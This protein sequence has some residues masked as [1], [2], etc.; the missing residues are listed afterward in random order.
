MWIANIKKLIVVVCQECC[1]TS[2]CDFEIWTFD[3]SKLQI[4]MRVA[5]SLAELIWLSNHT[6]NMKRE[7]VP[8]NFTVCP[9]PKSPS[10]F[11]TNK[12]THTLPPEP[13]S[14]HLTPA[15]HPNTP[16]QSGIITNNN[17]LFRLVVVWCRRPPVVGYRR[18]RRSVR[19]EILMLHRWRKK[20]LSPS[21]STFRV[22][23]FCFI[24]HTPL[25]TIC[26]INITQ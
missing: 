23:F 20:S 11:R 17:A 13:L 24:S 18:S 10:M 21:S 15:R 5:R 2:D 26:A 1:R 4:F 6:H 9:S 8:H 12:Q 19:C 14:S 7:S 16:T 3:L 22:C 25:T